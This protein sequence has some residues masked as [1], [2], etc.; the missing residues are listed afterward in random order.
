MTRDFYEQQQPQPLKT[1]VTS[2]RSTSLVR[3]L[4][5]SKLLLQGYNTSREASVSKMRGRAELQRRMCGRPRVRRDVVVARL[6]SRRQ[7]ALYQGLLRLQFHRSSA[8]DSLV[9]TVRMVVQIHSPEDS[10]AFFRIPGRFFRCNN[11][12]LQFTDLVH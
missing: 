1:E 5:R 8:N 3:C 9:G 12:H 10:N 4:T 2:C 6:K 7:M 11:G